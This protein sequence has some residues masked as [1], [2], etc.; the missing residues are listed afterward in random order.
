MVALK[1]IMRGEE[2][3]N[4]YGQLPRSDLLRRYGYLT[5]EYKQWDVVEIK[6]ELIVRVLSE[7]N[8]DEPNKKSRVN[9]IYT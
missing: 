3:F 7:G 1:P 8:P 2:I 4:D 9:G 5:N 6:A